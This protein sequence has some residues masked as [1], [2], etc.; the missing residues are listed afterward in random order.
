VPLIQVAIATDICCG[1][2]VP[3]ESPK[4]A[5]GGTDR[6]AYSRVTVNITVG[7][8]SCPR[9]VSQDCGDAFLMKA[10]LPKTQNSRRNEVSLTFFIV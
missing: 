2:V 3:C 8:V 5:N 6:K 4:Q 1:C 10:R 9:S 7:V